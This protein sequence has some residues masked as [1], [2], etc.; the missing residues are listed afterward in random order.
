[1]LNPNYPD[2][3]A[4]RSPPAKTPQ[5]VLSPDASTSSPRLLD[6]VRADIRYRHYSMKTERAYVMWIRR[7]V[8]LHNLRHPREMGAAEIHS[9][10]Q[11]L[12]N[13]RDVS[14]STHN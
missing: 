11:H 8:H 14:S 9:F 3:R 7:F 2:M 1:M 10:L 6:Q 5:S 4:S 13:D 12:A